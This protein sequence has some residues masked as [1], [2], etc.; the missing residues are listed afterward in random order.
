MTN[1]TSQTSYTKKPTGKLR[2]ENII[3]ALADYNDSHESSLC[4]RNDTHRLFVEFLIEFFIKLE[5][6]QGRWQPYDDLT[7]FLPQLLIRAMTRLDESEED[8]VIKYR[9]KY[10]SIKGT[11]TFSSEMCC[12]KAGVGSNWYLFETIIDTAIPGNDAIPRHDWNCQYGLL[13]G[14]W[15]ALYIYFVE[16]FEKIYVGRKA[17]EF[18]TSPGIKSASGVFGRT[19]LNVYISAGLIMFRFS[20]NDDTDRDKKISFLIESGDMLALGA[21]V[22]HCNTGLPTALDMVYDVIYNYDSV[23]FKANSDE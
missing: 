5:E 4:P 12:G 10:K 3:Q 19:K 7:P 14:A 20:R 9:N 8:W 23:K 16:F 21:R 1:L 13:S 15:S 6:E 11:G 22:L 2:I 17:R 18:M